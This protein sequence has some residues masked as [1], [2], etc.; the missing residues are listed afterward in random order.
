MALLKKREYSSPQKSES[1]MAA[2]PQEV[3]ELLIFTQLYLF[4][5]IVDTKK[6]TR[7]KPMYTVFVAF[8]RLLCDLDT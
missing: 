5:F 1:G 7:P 8:C 4:F 6:S 2:A 3:I